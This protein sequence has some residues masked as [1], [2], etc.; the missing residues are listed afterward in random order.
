MSIWNSIGNAFTGAAKA[1]ENAGESAANAAVSVADK[2]AEATVSGANLFVSGWKDVFSAN[3]QQGF[4]EVGFG[5]AKCLGIPTP[6]ITGGTFAEIIGE[7]AKFS[8][9]QYEKTNHQCFS[10]YESDVKK[11]LMEQN[12][13]WA[14][15]M[16]EPLKEGALHMPWLDLGC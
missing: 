3:F 8:L 7:A 12:I 2:V 10:E 14:A 11:R 1:V 5:M 15:S 16:E 9:Q 6:G 13:P 4:T